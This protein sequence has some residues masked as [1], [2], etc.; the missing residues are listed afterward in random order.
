MD[1]PSES[2]SGWGGDSN[3]E[4]MN[5]AVEAADIGT[6]EFDLEQRDG[7]HL[8]TMR[9]NNG[10]SEGF[11]KRDDSVQRL[12]LDDPLGVPETDQSSLRSGGR[13]RAQDAPAID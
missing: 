13:R 2:R 3:A 1:G 5:L 9:S 4:W 11:I 6:W 10:I 8:R 7:F 12:A